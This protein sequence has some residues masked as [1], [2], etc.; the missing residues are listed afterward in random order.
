MNI[1]VDWVTLLSSPEV[2]D[3]AD[4]GS[5]YKLSEPGYVAYVLVLIDSIIICRF[6][7]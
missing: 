2:P 7:N 4:G 5:R 3:S 6:T 1:A